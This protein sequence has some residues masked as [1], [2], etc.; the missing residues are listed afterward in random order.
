MF[1]SK[2]DFISPEINL[3]YKGKERHSSIASGILSILLF[4]FI[5]FL[6]IYLSIDCIGKLN[7][8]SFYFTKYIDDV[9]SYPLNSSSLL[10]YLGLYDADGNQIIIDKK[11]IN[12]IGVNIND[13][14]FTDDNNISKYSIWIYETC[15]ES[16]LGNLKEIYTDVNLKNFYNSLC[17][18][19]YYNLT[20]NKM[21]DKN[22]DNFIYPTLIHGA[23]QSNNFEY[24]V[25]IQKCQN[26]TNINNNNCYSSTGIELF[27]K[28]VIGYEIYFIDH[29][30]NVE[31]YKKPII[32]SIHRIT[33]EIN[34]ES[35]VLNHLN[36]HPVSIRTNDGLILDNN[37]EDT[38]F[39]FD[40]NEKITHI[41][42]NKGILGTFNF[43]MQNTIDTYDRTYK[44]IQ[45]IAGGVDG[46]IEIVMMIAKIINQIFIHNFIL[47]NDF[48]YEFDKFNHNK[49]KFLLLSPRKK[50]INKII[51]E[52]QAVSV[53]N[54]IYSKKS[55]TKRNGF[56]TNSSI[57]N[58]YSRNV[59]VSNN[60]K[61]MK[62]N[63]KFTWWNY[64]LFTF[65]IKKNNFLEFLKNKREDYI[66]EEKLLELTFFYEKNYD[67]KKDY[68]KL[69]TNN[70][71]D[72]NIY[73]ISTNTITPV[74]LTLNK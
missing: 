59:D 50:K 31:N 25:Y 65:T 52:N 63:K 6:I 68:E 64:I 67:F 54:D 70:M 46:I 74:P 45:D 66:S 30:V 41:N 37:K 44:K 51:T 3:F 22:D 62:K 5:I 38:T 14:I 53:I 7:P 49:N 10:H 71:E 60:K 35:Y 61:L 69:E 4:I 17:I 11:A 28:K 1:L 42:S 26:N 19:K 43:W 21:I 29:S 8:T 56:F 33:S 2:F 16:D 39:N 58:S 18:S 27:L 48:N 13:G 9:S 15:E 55:L 23:S 12:V 34:D 32:T 36:F 73:N 57:N 20:N 72:N 40:V 47:L 24:G